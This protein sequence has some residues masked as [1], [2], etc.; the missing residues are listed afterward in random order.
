MKYIGIKFA[1]LSICFVLVSSCA[2]KHDVV[3]KKDFKF[4]HLWFVDAYKDRQFG[5]KRH[6]SASPLIVGEDMFQGVSDADMIVIDKN[7]GSVKRVIRGSGPMESTPLYSQGVLYFGNNEGEVKAFSYRTGDYLW[8][9]KTGFPVYSTPCICDG[10]LFALGSNDVLYAFDATSGKE[11]WTVRKDFP[12]NRPVIKWSSSPVCYEDNV[13]VGFSDGSFAGVNIQSGSVV[14]EKKLT[15]RTKF[16][17]VDAT[18]YIDDKVIIVPSYDGNLYCLDR[19]TGSEQWSIKDGSAKSIKVD[20]DTVYFSSNEGI[21]YSIGLSSGNIKWSMKLK[22][23]IPTAPAIIGDHVVVG[24]SER[25]VMFYEKDNGRYAGEFN[26]GTG[27]FADPVVDDDRIYFLS[28]Y[29]VV[30]A[31]KRM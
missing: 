29:G 31:L 27:V 24:S 26:S 10:R 12:V 15:S 19:K 20:G 16:K 6:E 8:S 2:S 4:I 3:A 13:Y 25:G 23:G 11:L 22:A 28:N 21:L 1:V 17:D 30:Y 5:S 7:L 18:P 9:F 14:F